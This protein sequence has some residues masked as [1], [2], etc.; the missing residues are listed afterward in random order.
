M[1]HPNEREI[2]LFNLERYIRI[3]FHQQNSRGWCSLLHELKKQYT[4][5]TGIS[6]IKI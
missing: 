3:Y 6:E 1:I 5:K 4:V 2:K